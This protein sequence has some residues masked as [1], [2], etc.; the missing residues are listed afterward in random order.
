MSWIITVVS[1]F[2]SVFDRCVRICLTN[3]FRQMVQNNP[4][5]NYLYIQM[6]FKLP[7]VL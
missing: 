6:S 3:I 2:I 1:W 5:P 7:L 4:H